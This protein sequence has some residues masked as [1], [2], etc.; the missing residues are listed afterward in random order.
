MVA[1]VP[2]EVRAF[3]EGR[4]EGFDV[5]RRHFRIDLTPSRYELD[6]EF[7]GVRHVHESADDQRGHEVVTQELPHLLHRARK[8]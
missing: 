3:G 4:A 5:F 6:S 7:A 8:R 1:D 2:V